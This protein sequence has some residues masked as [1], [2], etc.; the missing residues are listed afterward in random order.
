MT[1]TTTISSNSLGISQI[2]EPTTAKRI[3]ILSAT[4]HCSITKCTFSGVYIDYVDTA[5]RSSA[6]GRQT[7]VEWREQAIFEIHMRQTSKTVWEI[8]SK[9]L[10]IANRK[11]H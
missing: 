9:L 6:R 5:G 3:Y 10:L 1:L 7:R 2:L 4:E 11:L 8:R